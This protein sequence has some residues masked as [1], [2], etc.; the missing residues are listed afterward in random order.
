MYTTIWPNC[1]MVRRFGLTVVIWFDVLQTPCCHLIRGFR[2]VM[3]GERRVV[4]CGI[5]PSQNPLDLIFFTQQRSILYC[6]PSSTHPGEISS[7]QTH[8]PTRLSYKYDHTSKPLPIRIFHRSLQVYVLETSLLLY[9]RVY[10][11]QM[12]E[13]GTAPTYENYYIIILYTLV[14]GLCFLRSG[15]LILDVRR[16]GSG[17]CRHMHVYHF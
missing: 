17:L 16:L 12:L 11:L 15:W 1:N 10:S 8:K 9:T 5:I 13:K 7:S 14:E 2:L 4:G 6:T 3:F